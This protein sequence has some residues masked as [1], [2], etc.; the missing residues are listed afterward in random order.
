MGS[1][2]RAILCL[3]FIV[4]VSAGLFYWLYVTQFSASNS[5]QSAKSNNATTILKA[6]ELLET[7]RRSKAI[8][9]MEVN[10]SQ[11]EQKEEQTQEE[12]LETAKLNRNAP[13]LYIDFEGRLHRLK[14]LKKPKEPEKTPFI[15]QAVTAPPTTRIFK[16]TR[17]S[18]T[19]CP[20]KK[21]PHT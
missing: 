12:L 20:E 9:D 21:E 14:D 5:V 4:G 3:V 13:Q 2:V 16:E 7:F 18:P 19:S 6:N 1:I 8:L 10:F 17:K 15:I 11:E